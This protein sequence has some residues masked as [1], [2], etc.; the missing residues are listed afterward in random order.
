[1]AKNILMAV[2]IC[3]SFISCKKEEKQPATRVVTFTSTTYKSLGTYDTQGK[4]DNLIVPRDSIS[5]S[6]LSFISSTLADKQDL[7]ITNP[8][9]LTSRAIADISITV[10]SDVFITYVS[11]GGG[12]TNTFAFYTYPTGNPPA[13]TKDIDTITYIFPN[14]GYL[15]PLLKGD[16]VKLGRFNP[17]TSIGFVIL[18]TAWDLTTHQLNNKVVHFCSNDILNPEVDPN[19]KKHAVLIDYP[20]EQKTLI[21]FEDRDRTDPGCD[22]DFN[23]VVFYCTV[24]P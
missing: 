17:G 16:K 10:A 19:L 24:K 12:Y 6:L 21:G 11:Q 2:F 18:Q 23:D 7:R 1:M 20:A 8:L 22:H 13:G 15:T 4:P 5:N 14:S 3:L 9:L